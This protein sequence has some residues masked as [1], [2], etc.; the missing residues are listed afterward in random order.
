MEIVVK[1]A[2][3]LRSASGVKRAKLDIAENAT[4]GDALECI[5]RE[6][7]RV[8]EELFG[9]EAKP[10]YSVFINGSLVPEK[11]RGTAVLHEGDEMM[12]LLPVAGG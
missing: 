10:Y 1:F 4:S 2:G 8:G 5:S 7:P 12:V 6:F 11:E 9:A 3:P